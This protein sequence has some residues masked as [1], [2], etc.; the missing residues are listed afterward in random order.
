[1]IYIFSYLRPEKELSN[2]KYVY[3]T[4]EYPLRTLHYSFNEM[5]S[6]DIVILM[7]RHLIPTHN[8]L[9][10]IIPLFKSNMNIL[11]F[12]EDE[13]E[14]EFIPIKTDISTE[15]DTII[16]RIK[17]LHSGLSD[18][19]GFSSYDFIRHKIIRLCDSELY[20]PSS[21]DMIHN[22]D[23]ITIPRSINTV[24]SYNLEN[25]KSQSDGIYRVKINMGIGDMIYARGVLDKQKNNFKQVHISPNLDGYNTYRQPNTDDMDFS[26]KLLNHLFK[27]PYYKIDKPNLEYPHRLSYLFYTFD[28]L[29]LHKANLADELCEGKPL[30]YSKPYILIPTRVRGCL[31]KDYLK[32]KEEF[33][34][35]IK[36]LSKKYKIV[37]VGERELIEYREQVTLMEHNIMF[38]I[39]NDI[40]NTVP[41]NRLLD[42]TFKNINSIHTNRF[43]KFKQECLY[44]KNAKY[45]IVL[46]VGGPFCIATAVGNAIVYAPDNY[47]SPEHK[48]SVTFNGYDY[49]GVY[50]YTEKEL[51]LNKLEELTYE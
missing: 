1:M 20:V 24:S 11:S 15:H 7:P 25:N 39:Y 34:S 4:D 16:F 38:L 45:N 44:M 42:L 17:H 48:L 40:K 49:N 36:I 46:G 23:I 26:F 41:H 32:I 9:E 12:K 22:T 14:Q 19:S 29:P 21:R 37:L 3:F 35:Y 10:K 27:P 51:F 50:V 6:R 28:K 13:P 31:Y 47:I 30:Y 2:V 5:S 8:Y 33:L 18:F 43:E